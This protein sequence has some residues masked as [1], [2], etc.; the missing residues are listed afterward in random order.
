MSEGYRYTKTDGKVKTRRDS[1]YGAEYDSLLQAHPSD[2]IFEPVNACNHRCTFCGLVSA[3][4]KR[5]LLSLELTKSLLKQAYAMGVRSAGFYGCGEPFLDQY[6]AERIRF[7]VERGYTY[8]YVTTNGG[9]ADHDSLKRVLDAGLSSLKFSINAGT[10]RSYLTVHGRDDFEKVLDNL[11]FAAEYNAERLNGKLILSVSS[12]N[13]IYS[14]GETDVLRA[15]VEPYVNELVIYGMNDQSGYRNN[16]KIVGSV[17]S[18]RRKAPCAMVFNRIHIK[19]EGYLS[20][21]CEDYMN[22]LVVADLGKTKLEDAWNSSLFVELRRRHL[23]GTLKGTMCHYCLTGEASDISP[24]DEKLC[25]PFDL[26]KV[27]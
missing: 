20:A 23:E 25:T 4:R 3:T 14:E 10:P 18:R 19:A 11:R 21:C 16:R 8:T 2:I 15:L 17:E 12:V 5:A 22:Y 6:L 13:S 27:V 7:A 1:Q 9:V 26:K 24:L